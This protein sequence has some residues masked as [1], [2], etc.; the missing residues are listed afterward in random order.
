MFDK[1]Y[2]FQC[3]NLE[4]FCRANNSRI[5][6]F[7]TGLQNIP[8]IFLET[9]TL[10]VTSH[11]TRKIILV[12]IPPTKSGKY[13]IVQYIIV[14]NTGIFQCKIDRIHRNNSRINNKYPVG[15]MQ[16]YRKCHLRYSCILSLDTSRMQEYRQCKFFFSLFLS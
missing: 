7:Y 8:N 5:Y 14:K 3:C 16:D 1:C 12:A 2:N 15:R 11:F 6:Q 10:K 9:C 13:Y 4:H